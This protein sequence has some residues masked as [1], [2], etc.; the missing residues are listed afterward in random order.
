M[1]AAPAQNVFFTTLAN[2]DETNGS[3]PTSALVQG[4]DGNFYG[5]TGAGGNYDDGTVFKM[6]PAGTLTTLYSFQG[7]SDGAYP[8]A[9]LVQGMDGNFYGTTYRGGNP[10]CS[11][12]GCG[13]VFMITPSG[14]LTT[15]HRF[16]DLDGQAPRGGL[17]Q[18]SDGNFYGTTEWGGGPRWC[19]ENGWDGCGTVFRITPSGTLTTLHNFDLTDGESPVS[20]LIQASDGNLYGTTWAGGSAG[21]GRS[22][23]SP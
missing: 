10:A 8:F 7:G 23:G 4:S 21:F 6:T 15:L 17:M 3:D 14:T 9:G 18:A 1:I 19:N 2:F 5:T 20:A 13:S 22:S 11:G 12:Q 16:D